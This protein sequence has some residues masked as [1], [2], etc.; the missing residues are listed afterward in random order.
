M[1]GFALSTVPP[2]PHRLYLSLQKPIGEGEMDKIFPRLLK[3][4]FN[5]FKGNLIFYFSFSLSRNPKNFKRSLE[6]DSI[7]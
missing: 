6:S 7:F 2:T 3:I 1:K 4:C 5:L